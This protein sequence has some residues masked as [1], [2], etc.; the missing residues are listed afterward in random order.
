MILLAVVAAAVGIAALV[1]ATAREPSRVGRIA[2]TIGL[3]TGAAI[4]P[5][6]ATASSP[7]FETLP[8]STAKSRRGARVS[9][10]AVASVEESS[11]SVTAR[12]CGQLAR[13]SGFVVSPGI[14]ATNA[15]AVAGAQDVTVASFYDD[16]T[17][18]QV[19]F[20][21]PL[22]DLA[23]VAVPGLAV[24]PVTLGEAVVGE[25]VIVVGHRD[26][27]GLDLSSA[28]V[29]ER[30][31]AVGFDIY[32]ESEVRRELL[33]LSAQLNEGLSGSAIVAEDGEVIGM[34]F[35]V[36]AQDPNTAYALTAADLRSAIAR[37]TDE[38]SAT[39]PCLTA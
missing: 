4:M 5:V 19:V 16:P 15:H 31:N 11:V 13:A 37:A 39:G 2:T 9:S 17:S 10:A 33:T 8:G 25:S 18:S 6:A 30:I 28:K 32:G 27:A 12:G 29:V 38:P 20:F 22:T 1:W 35:A 14:V 24:E 26:D 36:D 21:D 34:A 3:V 23:L 7:S